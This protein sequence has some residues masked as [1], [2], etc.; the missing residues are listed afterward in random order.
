MKALTT[1]LLLT[2]TTTAH[3]IDLDIGAT[4]DQYSIDALSDTKLGVTASY[5]EDAY[6]LM[7]IKRFESITSNSGHVKVYAELAAGAVYLDDQSDIE[8][9]TMF[10]AGIKWSVND[11][12]N[13]K[14]GY[15]YTVV[16][17]PLIVGSGDVYLGLG[18][19]F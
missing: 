10:G 3:A 4:G 15:R 1:A 14:T 16:D 7:V 9:A 8:L 17:N 6:S 13:V 18:F 11:T 19:K 12:F 5:K 2:L